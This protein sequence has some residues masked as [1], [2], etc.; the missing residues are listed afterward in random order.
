MGLLL[1]PLVAGG[2]GWR[3]QWSQKSSQAGQTSTPL[4]THPPRRTLTLS[5]CPPP[6]QRKERS[7]TNTTRPSAEHHTCQTGSS[8]WE[9]E[10]EWEC[11]PAPQ[12]QHQHQPDLVAAGAPVRVALLPAALLHHKGRPLVHTHRVWAV[13]LRPVVPPH[14]WRHTHTHTRAGTHTEK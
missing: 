2:W 6:R 11:P 8:Q 9:R 5:S 3:G 13:L 14:L 12:H 7:C 10:R 4:Y 1:E